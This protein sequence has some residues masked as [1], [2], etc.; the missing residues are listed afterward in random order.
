MDPIGNLSS[1]SSADGYSRTGRSTYG[2][3][4]NSSQNSHQ[5]SSLD[6]A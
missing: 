4:E 1:F 6:S 2:A 3:G 5:E